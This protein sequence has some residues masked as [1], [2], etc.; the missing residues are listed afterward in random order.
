MSSWSSKMLTRLPTCTLMQVQVCA[1][2]Y[3]H[4]CARSHTVNAHQCSLVAYAGLTEPHWKTP[5][6]LKMRSVDYGFR[7]KGSRFNYY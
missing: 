5:L 3:L 4:E 1:L 6:Q 2:M 7:L